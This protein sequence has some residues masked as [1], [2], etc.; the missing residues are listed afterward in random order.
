MPGPSRKRVLAVGDIHG[1][2]VALDALLAAVS[3]Q[4]EDLVVTLGDYVDRGP[5]SSGVMVR[6]LK[7]KRKCRLIALRGN[8]EAMMLAARENRDK[9]KEWLHYG[10]REALRSYS[11]LGDAGKLVDVPDEHWRFLEEE[12]RAW[13]ET[14]THFFVHANAYAELPLDEQ[15]D[16]MLYWEPF[17][18][19]PPHFSGKV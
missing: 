18:H 7:L 19:P 10:G 15:P 12:C 8:H 4:P 17:H 14:D 1:C 16:H 3:L 11:I 2:S 6:L 9:E 13:F 5:D